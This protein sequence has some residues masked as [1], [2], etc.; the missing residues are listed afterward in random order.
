MG[1]SEYKNPLLDPLRLD[2]TICTP[3]T[4]TF[5]P[6]KSLSQTPLTSLGAAITVT[7]LFVRLIALTWLKVLSVTPANLYD[8][9]SPTLKLFT[10]PTPDP[11]VTTP[12][13][14]IV[15]DL[16]PKFTFGSNTTS[17][18]KVLDPPVDLTDFTSVKS[19]SVIAVI[20]L[21]SCIPLIMIGSSTTNC[22]EVCVRIRD[23][24]LDT[25]LLR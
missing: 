7:V 19:L 18:A 25:A 21:P 15:N 1:N 11:L 14:V 16:P 12:P 3:L 13:E 24:E 10:Q 23:V 2:A 20:T 5:E 9:I 6:G 8:I 22:P 4:V 17:A